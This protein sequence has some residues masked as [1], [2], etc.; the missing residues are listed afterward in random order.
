MTFQ[1][2]LIFIALSLLLLL[3][4][5]SFVGVSYWQQKQSIESD[6][7]QQLHMLKKGF[8]AEYSSVE[9]A[10]LQTASSFASNPE[11]QMLFWQASFSQRGWRYGWQ[12]NTSNTPATL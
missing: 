4:H 11:V 9:Q 7:K 6:I 12:T 8:D 10:M 1:K 3:S 5:F 2:R